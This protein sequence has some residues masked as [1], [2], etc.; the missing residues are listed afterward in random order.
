MVPFLINRFVSITNDLN[1]KIKSDD[2][3][4]PANSNF[5]IC[6]AKYL[7]SFKL[8]KFTL[9]IYCRGPITDR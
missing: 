4:L 5:I 2:Y 1:L 3:L 6:D 7:T 8:G 9:D